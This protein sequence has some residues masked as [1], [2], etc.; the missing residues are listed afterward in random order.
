MTRAAK[1]PPMK[2][3]LIVFSGLTIF[4][5]LQLS[6]WIVFHI[7]EAKEKAQLE[8]QNHMLQS[9]DGLLSTEALA[10]IESRQNKL[11]VMFVSESCFFILI[12]LL[13]AFQIY[14]TL[15]QAEE[16]K[17]QQINF[18][19]AVTHE[20][21]TPI[22]SLRLY[23][24]TLESGNIPS[25]K[26]A[27]LYPKLIADTNRLEQLVDNVLEARLFNSETH[28]LNL[29]TIDFSCEIT[30]Y[31]K[32][33]QPYLERHK[34][35]LTHSIA[36]DVTIKADWTMLIRALDSLLDNAIKYSTD[37][38]K[39]DLTLKTSGRN[40]LLIIQDNGIGIEAG[41][42]KKVFN[43]FYRVG[44]ENTRTV[45]GTG[46]GLHLAHEI[47]LSHNGSIRVESGGKNKGAAFVIKLPLV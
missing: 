15:R 36:A 35:V 26:V 29:E 40:A 41:E 25:E 1:N 17:R 3:A 46:L 39:I 33:Y 37:D 14:R 20:F 27:E 8:K 42:Q 30:D 47:I 34:A 5:I 23:L 9:E 12:I 22:T 28:R 2:F 43:R 24:E 6:W 10:E 18:I 32:R 11:V 44:N 13:G 45:N 31:L 7:D 19:Q 16:L 38:P 4:C 21:R